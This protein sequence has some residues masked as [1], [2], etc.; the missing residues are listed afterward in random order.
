MAVM[1]ITTIDSSSGLPGLF[2]TSTGKSSVSNVYFQG[3]K[4]AATGSSCDAKRNKELSS[5]INGTCKKTEAGKIT[6]VFP[7]GIPDAVL[8]CIYG[9][10]EMRNTSMII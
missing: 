5:R 4:M 1:E 6:L 10:V 7:F 8:G 3:H 9:K 2:P